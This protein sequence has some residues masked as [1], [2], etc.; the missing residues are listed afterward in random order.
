MINPINPADYPLEQP[1]VG[2]QYVMYIAEASSDTEV[3]DFTATQS[4]QM[5][6]SSTGLTVDTTILDAQYYSNPTPIKINGISI[7]S[8]EQQTFATPTGSA[9]ITAKTINNYT[10][11]PLTTG[12][13]LFT[14]LAPF[15]IDIT[16]V[17]D[18]IT[19]LSFTVNTTTPT[20]FDVAIP[21]NSTIA[22][23]IELVNTASPEFSGTKV[24]NMRQ[25]VG[26]NT[27]VFNIIPNTT[28]QLV[29]TEKVALVDT[30]TL[31]QEES[32][33]Y[34][35]TITIAYPKAEGGGNEPQFYNVLLYNVLKPELSLQFYGVRSKSFTFNFA[36]NGLTAFSYAQTGTG[37]ETRPNLTNITAP[38]FVDA[39]EKIY[40][41]ATYNTACYWDGV[42]CGQVTDITSNIEYSIDD[43]FNITGQRQ[44][45]PNGRYQPGI[46]GGALLT[47]N[48]Y[49]QFYE[50]M[51]NNETPSFVLESSQNIK[52]ISYQMMIIHN[53]IKGKAT[54]IQVQEGV[55]Q[56]PLPSDAVGQSDIRVPLSNMYVFLHD[57]I[58]NFTSNI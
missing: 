40:S 2:S 11:A 1:N 15:T 54:P 31:T 32:V 58:P 30:H 3:I 8:G 20:T 55:L 27:T 23:V 33:Q 6:A 56:F 22:E 5:F 47:D 51:L 26:L 45:P 57:T 37:A 39:Y 35:S 48:S 38:Y 29:F 21:N 9:Y 42:Y 17:A 19:E 41:Q 50:D 44:N 46:S 7:V 52:G 14:A 24:L 28:T 16:R 10:T 18:V 4:I 25:W 43:I 12:I 34:P 53:F 13:T 36:N 49:K